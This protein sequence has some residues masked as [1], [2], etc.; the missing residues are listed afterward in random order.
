MT[1]RQE[2][3]LSTI[4]EYYVQTATPVGSRALAD[5]FGVSPATIRSEMAYLEDQ[6][7]ITHPHT[8]AGRIPTDAGYRFYVEQTL[9]PR[10][11]LDA[12]ARVR[13]AIEQRIGSAGSPQS[14]IKV[15]VDSL[16]H[17][18]HNVAFASMGEATYIKGFSQL[19]NQPEFS[20]DVGDIAGLLDNLE[21]WLQ[22]MQPERE[23]SAYI[24]EENAV[25]KSSGCAVIVAGYD[26]PYNRQGYIGVVGS[27]RQ[28]YNTVMRLVE[29]TAHSLEEV[30][31][32]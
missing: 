6:G 31:H 21:L 1:A 5:Q 9:A 12:T 27:T 4:V 7:Y 23:V 13:Q 15:A 20:E 11:K 24:G 2:R 26:S 29:H 25:G 19:F 16:V 3:V 28:N 10:S 18:T 14:A 8:S 17:V 30:L 22:E 32:E